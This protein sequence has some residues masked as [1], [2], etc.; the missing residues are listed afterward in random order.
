VLLTAAAPDRIGRA[1]KLVIVGCAVTLLV[2]IAAL[3]VPALRAAWSSE[4]PSGYAAGDRIDL[5][6]AAFNASPHTLLFFAR[7]DCGAC[8]RGKPFFA[9]LIK[10]IGAIPNARV[11]MIAGPSKWRDQ[12][13]YASG[14]GLDESRLFQTEFRRLR[15]ETV[16]AIVLVNRD[17]VV[18][19]ARAGL[20]AE[21][22]QPEV[23]DKIRDLAGR[24]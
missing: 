16:P 10:A 19:Y 20:P 4:L 2:T 11:L 1:A 7:A 9:S 15:L 8:Q 14:L 12:V 5:P 22:H 21:R 18:L 24:R 23:L 6:P 17:G 13:E 3:A